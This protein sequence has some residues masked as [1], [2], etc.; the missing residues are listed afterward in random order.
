MTPAER[1]E[2]HYLTAIRGIHLFMEEARKMNR[3][4]LEQSRFSLPSIE[5][6][7]AWAMQDFNALLNVTPA[8]NP[9]FLEAAE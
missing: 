1:A 4:E 7:A 9:V 3:D 5:A 2:R 6:N 8:S